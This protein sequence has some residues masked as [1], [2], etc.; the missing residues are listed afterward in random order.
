MTDQL[1]PGQLINS[2]KPGA[3]LALGK[4]GTNAGAVEARKLKSGSVHLYWR[5][6]LGAKTVRVPIG[7]YDSVAPPKSI[8]PTL[9]GYSVR[10][11]FRVAEGFA[12]EHR[13]NLHAGG[14]AALAEN[15][16]LELQR[17]E[18]AKLAARDL[19]LYSLLTDYCDHLKALGRMSHADARSIFRLH[20]RDAWP[21]QAEKQA[22]DV[23]PEEIADMMRKLADKG[24]GRTANKLRAYVRSAYQTAK[25]SRSK[26]SIPVAFK[27]YGITI[28]PAAE[29]AND[30]IHNKS[31]KN[32]LKEEELRVY[33]RALK[34]L[35]GFKGAVLRLH[36]LTGGQRIRQLVCLLTADIGTDHI[37]LHDG[38]GRPGKPPRPHA[39]PLVTA[40]A[41]A[42]AACGAVGEYA[43]STE[44]GETHLS[45]TTL[46]NWAVEAA[47]GAGILDFNAK[48]VRSGVE[49]LLAKAGVSQE[50][51][52]RL[53]SH[54]I[55]GVQARNYNDHDYLPEKRRALETL[56]RLLERKDAD[57]VVAIAKKAA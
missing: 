20:V 10:A 46:A 12:K 40:A 3:F 38:K 41:K 2:L 34:S 44:G 5:Y 54:G 53:Q 45:P 30:E 50:V 9:R 42:L 36:L 49:T 32:A 11:A 17:K 48:R 14:Y 56:Y 6:T 29:T 19:T 8:E 21:K 13:D 33:W 51:R 22:S 15:R 52:G 1:T 28:N 26:G 43:I 31:A 16:R 37:V 47:T 18:Q 57:N 7:S 39:V 35:D 4:V 24:L 23:T 25:D 27:A 55:S